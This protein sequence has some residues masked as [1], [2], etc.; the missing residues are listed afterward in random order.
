MKQ[1]RKGICYYSNPIGLDDPIGSGG[2]FE[3][4]EVMWKK[5]MIRVE[6]PLLITSS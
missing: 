3:E 5:L 6:D 4:S 2:R 1:L